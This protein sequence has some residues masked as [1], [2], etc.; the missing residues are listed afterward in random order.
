MDKEN[1]KSCPSTKENG[2]LKK[3]HVKF[4]APS[5]GSR[6]PLREICPNKFQ[7][8]Q[9]SN[10]IKVRKSSYR[11]LKVKKSEVYVRSK[12][13]STAETKINYYL[14]SRNITEHQSN[15]DIISNEDEV[16]V[17]GENHYF[18][19]FPESKDVD[20]SSTKPQP[21]VEMKIAQQLPV[22]IKITLPSRENTEVEKPRRKIT[23]VRRRN[24]RHRSCTEEDFYKDCLYD[25]DYFGEN[26]KYMLEREKSFVLR[27]DLLKKV[28]DVK[29][30]MIVVN[31]L[32]N[33]QRVLRLTETTLF[34]GIRMFDYVI[35][36]T[37]IAANRYSLMGVT[38]LWIANKNFDVHFIQVYIN[39]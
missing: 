16:F 4:G 5:A 2:P 25:N 15:G 32:I 12:S 27:K 21:K 10:N 28:S 30:R 23:V 14:E 26:Y 3:V 35:L 24:S 8:N 6:D 20:H 34:T 11:V 38:C 36:S 22:Q 33:V 18:K 1:P 31:W 13:S 37:N 17:E 39:Q 7:A 9:A 19:Y 29:Y